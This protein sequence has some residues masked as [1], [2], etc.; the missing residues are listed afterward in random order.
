METHVGKL[1]LKH[2][3]RRHESVCFAS[4]A[5]TSL[6]DKCVSKRQV[7]KS[8]AGFSILSIYKI[9]IY[10]FGKWGFDSRLSSMCWLK[11]S[12]PAFL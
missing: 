10:L 6:T 2:I 3:Q 5:L 8:E 1:A 11:E 9:A 12:N 7:S 4:A